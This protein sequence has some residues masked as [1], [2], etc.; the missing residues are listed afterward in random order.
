M[1]KMALVTQ[2]AANVS[3]QLH[4]SFQ[5]VYS[6]EADVTLTFLYKDI[7]CHLFP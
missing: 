3:I 7:V 6:R 1:D 4:Y 5:N 2:T